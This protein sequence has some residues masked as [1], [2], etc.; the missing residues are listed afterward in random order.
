LK[1]H[2]RVGYAKTTDSMES[3]HQH[4]RRSEVLVFLLPHER[5]P[6][7]EQYVKCC[8]TKPTEGMRFNLPTYLVWGGRPRQT[9]WTVAEL[10]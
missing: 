2:I 10:L 5:V 8:I 7:S 4:E 6:A 1:E 3:S 9:G